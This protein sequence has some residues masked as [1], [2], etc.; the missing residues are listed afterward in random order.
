MGMDSSFT[1]S[2]AHPFMALAFALHFAYGSLFGETISLRLII[3]ALNACRSVFCIGLMEPYLL[4]VIMLL[5]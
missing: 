5:H 2:R 4:P 1:L 3:A